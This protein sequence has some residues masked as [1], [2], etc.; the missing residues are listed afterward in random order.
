MPGHLTTALRVAALLAAPAA[1]GAQSRAARLT[2]SARA[3]VTAHH[4]DSADVLLRAALDSAVHATN[5]ERELAFVWRGI[6]EFLR[7]NDS[8][9]RVAFREALALD[10]SVSVG[11]LDG[12]APRLAEIFAEEKLAASARGL[13]YLSGSVDEAPRR[14][15]GP[16]VAYTTELLHRHAAGIVL[17]SAI[18]DT[19]GWAE[20]ASIRVEQTPDSGLIEPVRQMLLASRFSPGRHHGRLVRVMTVMKIPVEPPRLVATELVTAARAQLA[21]RRTDSALTLLDVALDTL[22]THATE[23]ERAYAL[24]ARGVAWST[25]GRDSVA[26][27][28]FSAALAVYQGLTGRGV[29]LA[30]FFR[31]LADS[32]RASRSGRKPPAGAATAG[33]AMGRPSALANVDEQPVLLSHP[34]IRYPPEMQAL[35]IG[36]TVIVEAVLD[37][38]GQVEPG[39]VKIVESPNPAFDAEARRVVRASAYRAATSHGRPVRAVIRQAIRFAN[40]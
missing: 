15:T 22:I 5:E 10:T 1:L 24:L 35:R 19:L 31:R 17:V 7:G 6:L 9:T 26:N 38:S 3:Q 14:S 34:P 12:L 20:P 30:P 36:G 40:Y 13:L 11:G 28:D 2:E 27:A 16:P 21:T 23:G 33:T 18:I 4:L 32:V 29:D 25:A 8:L 39:S 37:P